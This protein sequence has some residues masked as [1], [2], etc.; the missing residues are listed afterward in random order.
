MKTLLRSFFAL[1]LIV[2]F[3]PVGRLLAQEFTAD[4]EIRPRMEIRNGFKTPILEGQDPAA[5]VE[6]RS[7]L[8]LNFSDAPVS[9]RLVMQDVR[10]WGNHSQIYKTEANLSNVFEAWARY[11][12][13]HNWMMQFGR[14]QLDYD[15]AR[16]MGNLDWA[17]QGRSHDA[18]LVR[19]TNAQLRL[20]VDAAATWNQAGIIEPGHLTGNVYPLGAANNK[21]MQFLWVNKKYDRTEVSVLLHNDGRQ[22]ANQSMAWLQTF[23]TYI[24]HQFGDYLLQS[25]AYLQTGKDAFGNDVSAHFLGFD[26]SRKVDNFALSLGLDFSS[27]TESE[28]AKNKSFMPLYGTNHKFYGFM[29]YFHVGNPFRQPTGGFDVGFANVYQKLNWSAL[30]EVSLALNVH[31]FIAHRDV[32]DA[33]SGDIL[34]PYLGTELDFLVTWRPA[35]ATSFTAGYSVMSQN[36]T[37][38]AIK[39]A[40]SPKSHQSWAFVMFR[41]APRVFSS[42]M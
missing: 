21:T 23:G 12:F 6:Q 30:E 1:T 13:T 27:G 16:F 28:S 4:I 41:I 15:N 5:F 19:H 29:D 38:N 36:D 17:M 25:D 9:V 33:V 32:V 39:G 2:A 22:L 31:Q 18:L 8:A 24:R 14:M 20:T 3:A 34:N 42:G 7:R 10:V 37:M 40:G 35:P 26:S 11:R